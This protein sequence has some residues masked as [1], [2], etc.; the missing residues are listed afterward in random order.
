[1]RVVIDYALI[2]QPLSEGFR[3]RFEQRV[4]AA[5]EYWRLPELRRL[6]L[7]SLLK[8]IAAARPVR[9]FLPLEDEGSR[10]LLP[11]LQAI[12]ALTR[13]RA[14]EIVYPDLSREVFS[15]WRLARSL[16]ELGWASCSGL[17]S[18]LVCGR[19]LRRLARL[20]RSDYPLRRAQNLLYLKTNLWFGAKVGGSVG[21]VAGVVNALNHQGYAV[22]VAA[23]DELP[24]LDAAIHYHPVRPPVNFGFPPE[25]NLYRFQM[26][27]V[28]QVAR[29]AALAPRFIYQRMSLGNYAGVVLSRRFK[30]PL[31]LEYNGSEVWVQTNWGKPL[32]FRRLALL[33]E[34]V[35]LRHAHV[36]V[37][38]SEV[39]R[40]ELIDRGVEPRRIVTYPNCI[41]PHVFDPARFSAGNHAAVRAR[42]N[43]PSDAIVAGF[44]GTFGQWHGVD[45]LAQAIRHLAISHAD[46]LAHHKVHFL[47]IGDG[48][49]MPLVRDIL[50]DTR[51]HGKFTLTGLVAQAEAPRYLAACDLLLSPHVKN[52][53]GTRFFGSPTKLFEYMAMQ[54]PIVASNLDQIGQILH[55]SL[56]VDRL[57][58]T[59][60]AGSE[61]FLAVLCPPGDPIALGKGVR[62]LVEQPSWRQVLGN[63]SRA[64]ALGRYT[65]DRHVKEILTRLQVLC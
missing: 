56:S 16:V 51:C 4:G 11:I 12:A 34:D 8:T 43:V 63:N 40:D 47:I 17:S 15:R 18:L 6:S 50:S 44:I 48:L 55:D 49:K 38:V 10:T 7:R 26:S 59:G 37:T 54:R 9:L 60:P 52:P 61:T 46:W 14:I 23:A 64:E 35:C 28:D 5:P 53:D 65:W 36:V 62:F 3:A 39:L 42:Y 45:V 21:H 58:T 22:T 19:D 27:F 29:L 1:M 31:V 32:R 24:L 2:N 25:T 30:V 41:D 33:A 57:P 20:G 13:A